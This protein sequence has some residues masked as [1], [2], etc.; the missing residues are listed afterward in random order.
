MT[1]QEE[2]RVR[3]FGFIFYLWSLL[4]LAAY[5]FGIYAIIIFAQEGVRFLDWVV[6][7]IADTP[8]SELGSIKLWIIGG[9]AALFIIGILLAYLEIWIMSFIGA[10][11]V[12]TIVFGIPL[13]ILGGGIYCIIAE[14]IHVWI[15][16][17]IVALAVMLIV[18]ILLVSKR[19][20]LG[21]KIFE[22]SCEAV[23]ENKR[24]L[25]P[26]LIFA[27]MSII[28][29]ILGASA[30]VWVVYYME[31]APWLSDQE[32][33]LQWI[34]FFAII[35]VYLAIYWTTM[36]FTDA[37]NICIFKRWNNFKE[38]S[39]RYAMK[40]VWKVKGSIVM[41]GM[42]MAF[43]DWIVK[44]VQYFGAKKIKETSTFYKAFTI[45]KKVLYWVFIV[46][47]LLFKWLFKIIKFLNYYTLTIIVVE[48]QGFI[49]SIA[50]SSDLALDSGADIIIGKTGVN[51]AKGFF[52]LMT[53]AIFAVAGFFV[54]QYWF[55]VSFTS[56]LTELALFGVAVG[57]FFFI[58]GYLPMSA[59]LKPLNTAYQTILFFYLTDS[60]RGKP[61]RRSR[62]SDDIQESISRVK[63]DVMETY[64]KEERTSW[65]SEKKEQPTEQPAEG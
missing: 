18:V 8:V 48:K 4:T 29:F 34:V 44:I 45:M 43:F 61:G 64:D 50:R 7:W 25:L 17:G 38:S 15:G 13:V 59:L 28:T 6:A 14:N 51:I 41:F 65:S 27:I 2:K 24:T 56:D 42:F 5:A 52:S 60:F 47:V 54:G 19:I 20:V 55:G 3:D 22:S 12:N 63:E 26:I 21:A 57:V 46:F 1:E 39:I 30:S 53:F 37:I 58:F 10:E 16:I 23:N 11:F 35:Y 36:Y 31:S 32:S 9:I 49:R 33:W 40:D 62:L